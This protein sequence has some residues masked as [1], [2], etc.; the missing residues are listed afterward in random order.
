[1]LSPTLPVV[2]ADAVSPFGHHP[3][4]TSRQVATENS[5]RVDIDEN[6]VLS[7]LGVKVGRIVVVVEDPDHDS[8]EATDLRHPG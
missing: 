4:R 1:M 7:V 2:L 6:L 8:V 3:E 5:E